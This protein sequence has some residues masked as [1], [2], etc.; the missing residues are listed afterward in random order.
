MSLELK[1]STEVQIYGERYIIRSE[2][3]TEAMQYIARYV[4][5]KM[6]QVQE[7]TPLIST[8]RIAVMA[9]LNIA[10]ELFQLQLQKAHLEH[11]VEQKSSQLIEL[12]DECI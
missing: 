8:S 9:A 12:L 1:K 3:N 4:D 10:E 6:Q 7:S 5:K 11:V 2:L